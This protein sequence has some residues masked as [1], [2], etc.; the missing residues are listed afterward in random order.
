M[1]GDRQREVFL[2]NLF[3]GIRDAEGKVATARVK[4]QENGDWQG[5]PKEAVNWNK[6]SLDLLD[7]ISHAATALSAIIAL[8]LRP[9]SF[10][11]PWGKHTPSFLLNSTHLCCQPHGVTITPLCGRDAPRQSAAVIEQA[12]AQRRCA[13]RRWSYIA[14]RRPRASMISWSRCTPTGT[15]S[16]SWLWPQRPHRLDSRPRRYLLSFGRLHHKGQ[17][18]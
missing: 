3:G 15:R 6:N 16:E 5:R 2:R 14:S 17:E 1:R 8:L 12:A 7:P 11:R 18:P 9:G 4:D 13:S 10:V